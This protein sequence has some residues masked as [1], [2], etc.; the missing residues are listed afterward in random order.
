MD[1]RIGV[2]LQ[3][4][5]RIYED[6]FWLQN[7]KIGR[8]YLGRFDNLH[9]SLEV[10]FI[11]SKFSAGTSLAVRSNASVSTSNQLRHQVPFASPRC[12]FTV[13]HCTDVT[14]KDYLQCQHASPSCC[15][16]SH[17]CL[18]PIEWAALKDQCRTREQV[19]SMRQLQETFLRSRL[20]M[21]MTGTCRSQ[22][23]AVFPSRWNALLDLYCKYSLKNFSSLQQIFFRETAKS[24]ESK[25][26]KNCLET[27]CRLKKS[28]K[29]AIG[30][31]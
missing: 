23:V 25:L 16:R 28:P 15:C 31:N 29:P 11:V 12:N 6:S 7:F 8:S 17:F 20:Q 22:P 26:A 5:C 27:D 13:D 30:P 3:M 2:S 19:I 1:S 9:N 18:C 21:Q 4:L 24:F 14:R 10:C